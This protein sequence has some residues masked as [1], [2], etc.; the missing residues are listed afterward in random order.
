MIL[1][2][3]KIYCYEKSLHLVPVGLDGGD[4][5]LGAVRGTKESLGKKS[6]R[7]GIADFFTDYLSGVKGEFEKAVWVEREDVGSVRAMVWEAWREANGALQEEK[8]VGVER[9]G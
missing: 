1:Q 3:E 4:Y 7:K 6:Y 8:L 2:T 5:R 9:V